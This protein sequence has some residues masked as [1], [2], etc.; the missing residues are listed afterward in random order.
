VGVAV[1]L[2]AFNCNAQPGASDSDQQYEYKETRELVALVKDAA[3][4]VRSK[5]ET[6]FADFRVTGSRWR[7][8]DT[9][10]FVVDPQG[11]MFVHPNPTMEGKNELDLKDI[12]GKPVIGGLIAAATALT[13][14]PEGWYHYEWPMPGWPFLRWKSTYGRLVIAPSGKRY[15]VASG[16]YDDRMERP[17][18]VDLVK[19]AVG[20]IEKNGAAAFPLFRDPAAR[21]VAKDAYIFVVEPDGVVLVDYGFPKL[22]GRNLMDVTETQGKQPIRE[23]LKIAQT[24]GSGWVY[25]MQRSTYV[26]KAKMGNRWVLVGCGVYTWLI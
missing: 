12:N 20:Q 15:I 18:V 16:I 9:Y 26:S 7:Q 10:I 3:D 14:K 11:N 5:G 4:L 13:D 25:Y 21:F 6:A 22:E 1:F 17:F 23:M 19:D 24:S 8:G 2:G